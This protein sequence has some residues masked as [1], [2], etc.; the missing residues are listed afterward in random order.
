MNTA[1]KSKE[2]TWNNGTP[3]DRDKYFTNLCAKLFYIFSLY[4]YYY[5]LSSSSVISDVKEIVKHNFCSFFICLFLSIFILLFIILLFVYLFICKNEPINKYCFV[6]YFLCLIPILL[7]Y[8]C[9]Q[10]DLGFIPRTWLTHLVAVQLSQPFMNAAPEDCGK[11]EDGAAHGGEVRGHQRVGHQAHRA[12]L[13]I[14][15]GAKP[16]GKEQEEKRFKP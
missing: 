2:K 9:T 11:Q 6:Y 5:Y 8:K 4:Y 12:S 15:C 14:I 10:S 13:T 3:Q 7:I 1:E 16:G